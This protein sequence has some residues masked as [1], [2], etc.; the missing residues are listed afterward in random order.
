MLFRL[1][2]K[3]EF[4]VVSFN[5]VLTICRLATCAGAISANSESM[6]T[7]STMLGLVTSLKM[8]MVVD[9]LLQIVLPISYS[10][11]PSTLA[12]KKLLLFCRR[13]HLLGYEELVLL[14]LTCRFDNSFFA[15]LYP[16]LCHRS[17]ACLF[18]S[19]LRK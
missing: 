7:N 5:I 17:G 19:T 11:I 10:T 12:V 8:M 15:S 3:R 18:S 16:G 13:F 2:G 14:F 1:L 9:V 6:K 4:A